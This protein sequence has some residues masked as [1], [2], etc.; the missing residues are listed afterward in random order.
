MLLLLMSLTTTYFLSQFDFLL[1]NRD[2]FHEISSATPRRRKFLQYINCSQ[3][4]KTINKIHFISLLPVH[5]NNYGVVLCLLLILSAQK[6]IS[7]TVS[8]NQIH[9]YFLKWY[10]F[11]VT[12]IKKFY[13]HILKSINW[14][15]Y[16]KYITCLLVLHHHLF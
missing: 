2:F 1:V 9:W 8:G 4:V 14:I 6:D 5:K 10:N 15:K 11:Q 3:I 16:I 13:F 7:V 12:N